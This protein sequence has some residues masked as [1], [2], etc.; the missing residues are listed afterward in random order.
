MFY[1]KGNHIANCIVYVSAYAVLQY[2]LVAIPTQWITILQIIVPSFFGVSVCVVGCTGEIV[3]RNM[4]MA[5]KDDSAI[6]TIR[7]KFMYSTFAAGVIFM[8][9][10]LFFFRR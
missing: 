2:L 8:I 6:E 10:T 5:K 9:V 3:L 7:V 4:K 1:G